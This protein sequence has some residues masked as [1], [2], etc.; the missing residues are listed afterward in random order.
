VTPAPERPAAA[1]TA[2]P[3]A[4]QAMVMPLVDALRAG[5]ERQDQM[6]MAVLQLAQALRDGAPAPRK[7]AAARKQHLPTPA[8][9][10]LDEALETL[11]GLTL[12]ELTKKDVPAS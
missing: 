10:P 6:N 11:T 5:Q 1:D 9:R 12:A 7:P 3:Q 4:L 2:L 8:E